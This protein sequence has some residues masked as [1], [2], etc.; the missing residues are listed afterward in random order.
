MFVISDL[1]N[2]HMIASNKR[3]GC[4][5]MLSFLTV[6]LGHVKQQSSTYRAF[7]AS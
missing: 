6:D 7:L 5:D 4:V 2:L 1:E 3:K